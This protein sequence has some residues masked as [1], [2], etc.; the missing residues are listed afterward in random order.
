MCGLFIK[1]DGLW[2]PCCGCRLRA[3]PRNTK[4]RRNRRRI[5]AVI[6]LST[7]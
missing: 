5:S 4:D 7:I 6:Y 2:C 1:W 3:N